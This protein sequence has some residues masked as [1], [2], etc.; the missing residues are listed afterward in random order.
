MGY[1]TVDIADIEEDVD[2]TGEDTGGGR[3]VSPSSLSSSQQL[4]PD[5]V[6]VVVVVVAGTGALQ[7]DGL[8]APP[9]VA[10]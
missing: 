10:E 3:S 9:A 5:V 2:S 8:E 7:T 6:V 4:S 1:Q